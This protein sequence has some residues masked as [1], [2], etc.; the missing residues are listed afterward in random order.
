MQNVT[1]IIMSCLSSY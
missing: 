1:V